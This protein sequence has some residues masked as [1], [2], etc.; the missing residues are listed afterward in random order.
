MDKLHQNQQ[1]WVLKVLAL[2]I[3]SLTACTISLS[4]VP[5]KAVVPLTPT[6]QPTESPPKVTPTSVPTAIPTK[7]AEVIQIEKTVPLFDQF[8]QDIKTGEKN[9]IVGLWVDGKM[10]L[11]VVYQPTSNPG[12][13][14]SLDNVATYFLLPYKKAGNYGMLA[15]NYLAGRFFFDMTTGDIIQV[16]FGDGDYQDFEVVDIKEYQALQPNSP[17][18]DYVDL[19]SGAQLTANNLFYEVYMGDFHTTLQTCIAQGFEESWGRRFVLA[20]P[21]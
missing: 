2:G 16:V 4:P 11:T 17:R 14:S 12:F 7:V 10:A 19:V 8:I 9:K 6:S 20:P 15:H 21:L 3:Y 1:S 5:V 18:S 13:V